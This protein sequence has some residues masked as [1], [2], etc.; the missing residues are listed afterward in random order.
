MTP[1][2]QSPSPKP[3]RESQSRPGEPPAGPKQPSPPWRTEGLP[4]GQP[5]KRRPRWLSM[6]L[7]AAGSL[8]LFTTLTMQDRLSRTAGGAVHGVQEPGRDQERRA[9]CLR[10]ATR[11]RALKK[12]RRCPASRIART[13]KFTTERPTFAND[14]LLAR[15]DHEREPRCARR[16]S[17]SSAAFLTNLSFR[18]APILLLVAFY[19]WMFRRQQGAMGGMLGG[20]KAEARRSRDRSRHLRRCR[21]HRRGRGRDQRGRR[22][23]ARTP[24]STAGSGRA[25]RKACCWPGLPA[26]ARRCSRAPP[27]ARPRCRSSAPARRSSSR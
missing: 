22:L 20:G 24:T 2:S 12:A 11:S 14:D 10:A 23:P 25:R 6:A 7:W 16:R 9:R 21:R 8:V 4:P 1:S 17:S 19:V 3:P 27:P 26:P 5:P 15:A 13:S 18:S